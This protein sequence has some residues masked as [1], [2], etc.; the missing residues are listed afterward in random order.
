MTSIDGSNCHVANVSILYTPVSG[1]S[2]TAD[3]SSID[4]VLVHS[5]AWFGMGRFPAV[6]L[7]GRGIKANKMTVRYFGGPGITTDYIH[8]LQFSLVHHGGLIGKD[9]AGIYTYG[10][11]ANGTVWRY[12]WVHSVREKCARG[13][14]QTRNLTIHNCVFWD[15]GKPLTD[16][17]P[18]E[19]VIVKG[20]YNT[21]YANTIFNTASASLSLPACMEPN[22]PWKKHQLPRVKQNKHTQVVNVALES[23]DG[24]VTCQKY[25][26]PYPVGGNQTAV[27]K[28]NYTKFKLQ[29]VQ[30]YDFRPAP[31]SPLIGAGVPFHGHWTGTHNK[32]NNP[33]D[34]GA[35]QHDAAYWTP[36]CTHSPLCDP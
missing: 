27:F 17:R 31:G 6:H 21:I 29:N 32:R 7:V 36:G 1:L 8:Y 5:T 22:K 34:I 14:D 28:G 24:I 20:D 18:V 13:D 25:P 33:V 16:G 4:N 23:E 11:Q 15:C 30:K 26:P 35:Y 2:V 10:E 9:T 3:N 12:N 19:G